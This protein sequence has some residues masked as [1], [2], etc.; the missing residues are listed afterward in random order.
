MRKTR[1]A[2]QEEA[3]LKSGEMKKAKQNTGNGKGQEAKGW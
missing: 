3:N 2:K 1:R